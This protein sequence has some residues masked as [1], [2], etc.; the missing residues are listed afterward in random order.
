[1]KVK[2]KE[3]MYQLQMMKLLH[4]L[5][6]V[7]VFFLFFLLFRYDSLQ[8]I[9]SY[10]FRYNIFVTVVYGVMLYWLHR[11]YN[12]Y[13]L[14]FSS[15][16]TLVFGQFTSQAFS[17][18]IIYFVVSIGWFTLRAPW[19]FLP[20]LAI[21][22]LLDLLWS[23]L[24]TKYYIKIT[25]AKKTILIYR[26]ER[27]LRRLESVL[28][29][30]KPFF[31]IEKKLKFDGSFDELKDTL[32]DYHGVFVCGVNASCQNEI[33]KYCRLRG[34][35]MLL[36]PHVGDIL[37]QD[38]SHI[39]SFD[40]PVLYSNKKFLKPGY[41]FFKRV[42]DILVSALLLLLLSPLMLLIALFI[43]LYDHGPVIY[44][45]T[46]LTKDGKEFCILK[47]RSMR[48]DAEMDG[49]ARLSS[50]DHDDRITPVGRILRKIRLDEL[51]Q[52]WNILSGDMSMVGPRPERP[53]IAEEYYK[54]FPDFRLRLQV[55]AGLTGYAQVYGRY[56][57]D[58]FE[59]LEFDLLYINKMSILTDLQLCF[60]TFATFF[61]KDST[62]GVEEGS[63][64]ALSP[65]EAMGEEASRDHFANV[66]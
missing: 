37:M 22:F 32:A 41:R 52:L 46:R 18:V 61:S 57:S 10:G 9:K 54:I 53:E 33:L 6:T 27:D 39:Q 17:V 62:K 38:A 16:R 15:I 20:M 64:T 29:K 23:W 3:R 31:R 47:F 40:T 44:R 45:Q 56:N 28:E 21:Q 66:G 25:P 5:L 42:F 58:P 36:L 14:G 26:S 50:G 60:A 55:K 63:L 49:V 13:L 4:L 2:K 8:N 12:A 51:P 1:M 7:A 24:A 59:K 43:K 65:A 30:S 19:V 11:T 48:V 34:I 35:S